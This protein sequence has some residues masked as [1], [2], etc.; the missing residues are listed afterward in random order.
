VKIGIF[1]S[2]HYRN[3]D[4]PYYE[5]LDEVTETC[6]YAEELGFDGI[7]IPEHHFINYITNPSALSLAI[8]I[9]N[10]TK[11]IK[12]ITA[13]VVL[14]F[15]NPL[16]LAEEIALVDHISRGRIELGV[17]RGANNYEFTRMGVDMKKSREMYEEGLDVILGALT[18]EDFA[19]DGKHYKFPKLTTMPRPY[20]KPHP[21]VWA[22]AQS[23]EGLRAAAKR[24][25]NVL[26][27][28]LY[29]CFADLA[30]FQYTYDAYN[31]ALRE[32]G[33]K[34]K[35]FGILRRVYVGETVKEA[36]AQVHELLTHWG[37]YM[38]FHVR[39]GLDERVDKAEV[40]VRRGQVPPSRFDDMKIDN[41]SERYDDPILSD[42]DGVA[43]RL[44]FYESLG[45]T[46]LS[47]NVQF[48]IPKEMVFRSMERLAKGVMPQLAEK[49]NAVA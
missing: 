46:W 9:A 29:G 13:V 37:M 44:K 11:R 23:P 33:Q 47:A 2:M 43:K 42:V 18:T 25:F 20:T 5:L 27:S 48:G 4:R 39:G 24:G 14:P 17:A 36:E 34:P 22:T 45:V 28:P 8:H 6:Q 19:W 21:P 12:L 15:W 3:V 38:A 41:I 31:D 40:D 35:E 10:H 16:V 32:T 49:E 30:A 7:F 1:L 26:T